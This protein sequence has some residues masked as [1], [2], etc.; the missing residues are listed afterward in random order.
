[1]NLKEQI[2]SKREQIEL[3]NKD[4]ASLEKD[5][6]SLENEYVKTFKV[7]ER[8]IEKGH[9]HGDGKT[10]EVIIA[11]MKYEYF[12]NEP[13]FQIY[14]VSA[15]D[16]KNGHEAQAVTDITKLEKANH[17]QLCEIIIPQ[18]EAFCQPCKA[19]LD[20]ELSALDDTYP[21]VGCGVEI[22]ATEP[23]CSECGK[24]MERALA[25]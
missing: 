2:V 3:A 6:T 10:T 15:A 1:M 7:G 4:L 18:G 23:H 22:P 14:T 11:A 21:C 16:T 5:L 20:G 19:E 13:R 24:K 25:V 17:C 9:F 12:L 8:A